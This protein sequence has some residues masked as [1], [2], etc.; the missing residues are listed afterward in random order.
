MLRNAFPKK[1]FM[2]S[3]NTHPWQ[4]LIDEDM[5]RSLAPALRA[6]G[7][8]VED[9]RDV[10]LR[11][12][13]DFIVF[14]YAQSHQRTLITEDMGFSNIFQFRLGSHAGIIVCRFPNLLPTSQVNQE[15]LAG[16]APLVGQSL[17][18]ILI[19]IEPGRVRVRRLAP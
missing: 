9:G 15:I 11:G 3:I 10:G 6:A 19:I 2:A 18:G 14:A 16:L 7:Y 4:F 12:R 17:A 1:P 5:P 13:D 8:D